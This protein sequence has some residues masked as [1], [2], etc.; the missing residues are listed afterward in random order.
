M[1][2]LVV[3]VKNAYSL[4]EVRRFHETIPE[5]RNVFKCPNSIYSDEEREAK[6]TAV[7]LLPSKQRLESLLK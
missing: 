3:R 6:K 2:M 1:I 7:T 5:G 4:V